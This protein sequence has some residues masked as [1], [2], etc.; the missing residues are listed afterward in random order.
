MRELRSTA[1][2]VLCVVCAVA[3]VAQGSPG[4]VICIENELISL[5]FSQE[6]GGIVSLMDKGTGIEFCAGPVATPALFSLTLVSASGEEIQLSSTDA[7]SVE[8]RIVEADGLQTL[9]LSARNLDG[10][11]VD[12]V[13]TVLVRDGTPLTEWGIKVESSSEFRLRCVDF[14][15]LTG[16]NSLGE[17]S[18]DDWL[19]YPL[20]AGIL[21]PRP[22]ETLRGKGQWMIVYY[23]SSL[24][25]Q[26]MAVYDSHVGLYTST[27]D[28]A[29]T[30]KRFEYFD[31]SSGMRWQVLTGLSEEPRKVYEQAYPAVVGTFHGDWY[32][33]ADIYKE[34]ALAQP[35]CALRS[36]EKAPSWLFD[37]DPTLEMM[38]YRD[39]PG[40]SDLQWDS[41][42]AIAAK[43]VSFSRELRT[44][45]DVY[46]VGWE[47]HEVWD[48]PF[49]MPP[50]ESTDVFVDMLRTLHDQGNRLLI[51][52]GTTKWADTSPG[53]AEQG[54]TDAIRG[55]TGD[56]F[57]TEQALSDRTSL[58]YEM[59]PSAAG[60]RGIVVENSAEAGAL[61]VDWLSLDEVPLGSHE[62]ACACYAPGHAHAPGAG[63]WW[64]QETLS[65]LSEARAAGKAENSQMVCSLESPSEFFLSVADSYMARRSTPDKKHYDWLLEEFPGL[66]LPAV[67]QYVYNEY[68]RPW[69]GDSGVYLDAGVVPNQYVRAVLAD[70]LTSAEILS[71]RSH[72]MSAMG[73]SSENL[74]TLARCLRV[75]QSPAREFLAYGQM[76][77]PPEID[78]PATEVPLFGEGFAGQTREMPAVLS[79]AWVSPFGS[80]GYLFSNISDESVTVH[81]LLEGHSVNAAAP[82][83]AYVSRNG[84]PETILDLDLPESAPIELAPGDIVVI[85]LGERVPDAPAPIDSGITWQLDEAARAVRFSLDLRCPDSMPSMPSRPALLIVNAEGMS[86]DIK[87]EPTYREVPSLRPG[88]VWHVQGQ[89]TIPWDSQGRIVLRARMACDMPTGTALAERS[90]VEVWEQEYVV[91]AQCPSDG[92]VGGECVQ[93]GPNPCTAAGVRIPVTLTALPQTIKWRVKRITPEGTASASPST[94]TV[95]GQSVVVFENSAEIKYGRVAA[96]F[97]SSFNALSYD[98]IEVIASASTDV[99]CVVDLAFTDCGIQVEGSC[100]WNTPQ[101]SCG[102]QVG[103]DTRR[104]LIPFERFSSPPWL[105]RKYPT[106]NPKPDLT[107]LQEIGLSIGSTWETVTIHSIR[108]YRES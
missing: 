93:V 98:G 19:L 57:Y 77:R 36:W 49:A 74:E 5:T 3:S 79:S 92:F 24:S 22:S 78:V 2:F 41:L 58:R 40:T 105:L 96:R 10:L 69:S 46:L 23:P 83:T 12:V 95:A 26:F 72:W 62:Y 85:K 11:G 6:S 32:T 15:I 28:T 35:W 51:T 91:E 84:Y 47:G 48:S 38:N 102:L 94:M 52:R 67:F 70:A 60:W 16:V 64:A 21:I 86:G 66:G 34:W 8:N 44:P 30:A 56:L 106:A 31:D 25:M 75:W 97:V 90:W 42:A 107:Q 68:I 99:N 45:V 18:E 54:L 20:E 104:F 50:R 13:C 29:G 76:L 88:Q 63:S 39:F 73:G 101:L 103:T 33:A 108:F 65:L 100:G 4:E 80:V 9:S 53:F 55:A 37:A 7:L 27:Y 71:F 17:S 14:P 89:V 43:S 1:L 59:C 61:G 87:P 81:P 82:V